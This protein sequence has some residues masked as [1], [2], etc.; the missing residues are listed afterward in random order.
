MPK[1]PKKK[2]ISEIKIENTEYMQIDYVDYELESEDS[3][4]E[5]SENETDNEIDS[6]IDESNDR[7]R[8]KNNNKGRIFN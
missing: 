2:Q 5:I 6:E 1:D 7:R 3:I 4:Y 8:Y